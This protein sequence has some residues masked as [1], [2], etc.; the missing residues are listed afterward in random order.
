MPRE[1][2]IAAL[3]ALALMTSASVVAQAY[4]RS[5]IQMVQAVRRV[6]NALARYEYPVGP[7]RACPPVKSWWPSNNA[8]LF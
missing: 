5:E 3:C 8:G 1:S 2:F 4:D 7:C 6:P